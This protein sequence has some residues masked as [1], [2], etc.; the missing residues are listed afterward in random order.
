M[1]FK[2]RYFMLD[3]ARNRV[4]CREELSDLLRLLHRLEYN[5]LAM[6][7]EGSFTFASMPGVIRPG[8]MTPGDVEWLLAEAGKYG[9]TVIPITNLVGHM[10]Q[11]FH[12]ERFSHLRM[13][14]PSNPLVPLSD[15]LD[16]TRPEA[17]AFAMNIAHEY[18]RFFHT[19]T[20]H[21]GGDETILTEKTKPL[22]AKFLAKLCDNLLAEGVHPGIWTDMIWMDPELSDYFSREVTL[23]DWSYYGHRPESFRFWKEK[24]FSTIYACP[25]D[26]GW[27]GF[28]NNQRVNSHL[29]A[30][31]DIPVSPDESEA[32]LADAMAEGTHNALIT[33]WENMSGRYLWAQLSPIAR[34]GL[35]MSGKLPGDDKEAQVEQALFGH[36]TPYTRITRLLQQKV[37]CLLV[38]EQKDIPLDKFARA[39][40]PVRAC[41]WKEQFLQ[42][43]HAAPLAEQ[44]WILPF[45]SALPELE[46]A[47]DGWNPE[48]GIETR[49]YLALKAVV[50]NVRLATE[51]LKL[52]CYGRRLYHEAALCQYTH[53]DACRSLLRQ[54]TDMVLGLLPVYD[55]T[56]S[57][58]SA[59][60]DS[61]GHTPQD[62]TDLLARKSNVTRLADTLEELRSQIKE[63]SD[64]ASMR[65]LPCWMDIVTSCTE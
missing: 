45:S 23:F 17:E 59:A 25:S 10:E 31:L 41:Y 48:K 49:G 64:A 26:N 40:L 35:F 4:F 28:I 36:V 55:D 16:F 56:L 57:Q 54:C 29:K 61:T 63:G 47:F 2:N 6:H 30:R 33:N 15:Q 13:D 24:G 1:S 3:F 18:L 14:S 21:I 19:D 20:L 62:K 34:D 32:L 46:H 52:G 58:V 42:L 43:F 5:G 11:F 27:E 7:M 8:V 38:A 53:P 51:L 50:A 44:E 9:I 60:I 37:Q 65:P 39:L 22:Y 12:Q